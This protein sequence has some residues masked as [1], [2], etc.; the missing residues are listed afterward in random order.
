MCPALVIEIVCSHRF[1]REELE[2]RYCKYFDEKERRVKV[3]IC[4]DLYYARGEHRAQKT[5]DNLDVRR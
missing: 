1:T 3:L 5:A 4:T 2:E